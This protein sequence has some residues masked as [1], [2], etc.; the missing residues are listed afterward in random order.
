M[1]LRAGWHL[2]GLN[3]SQIHGLRIQGEL[4]RHLSTEFSPNKFNIRLYL[5]TS[6]SPY[7]NLAFEDIIFQLF[8]TKS[9][10]VKKDSKILDKILYLYINE[11]SVVIGRN[12]N[13]WKE[14]II[15]ILNK[16]SINL[17]RRKSG[18]GTVFHDEGNV[19]YSVI[20]SID[21][22][23]R[24][25]HA[26]SICEA[27]N[28]IIASKGKQLRVNER[29]DIVDEN[30]NKVSGSAYKL[31]RGKAYHHG[32]MLLNS[33]I[34]FLLE[35]LHKESVYKGVIEGAGVESVKSPVTNV[36]ISNDEFISS[37]ASFF[38]NKYSIDCSNCKMIEVNEDIFKEK[39][40]EYI[41]LMQ[42]K[43]SELKS[44]DWTYGATPKFTHIFTL[45]EPDN[46]GSVKFS[47]ANGAVTDLDSE[48]V[49]LKSLKGKMLGKKYRASDLVPDIPIGKWKKIISK[50]I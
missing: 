18:G 19:N 12:Q 41:D 43:I 17:V 8:P 3:R 4:I 28:P 29:H 44:W 47:V 31:Q 13:P 5:S 14:T 48:I 40:P 42:D 45:D 25:E 30:N 6:R 20:N 37:V 49:E 26:I 10:S 34:E 2:S 1:L 27:L 39:W 9:N 46:H 32:T 7:F 15:P 16:H 23:D 11:P 36:G 50:V 35:L 21:F 22:F 24:D 33:K 38:W